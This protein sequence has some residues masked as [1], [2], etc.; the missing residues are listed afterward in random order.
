MSWIPC[1]GSERVDGM[2][3][4]KRM[5]QKAR[6]AQQSRESGN[7]LMNGYL[8]G[9]NDFM[10]GSV[11]RFLGMSDA[12]FSADICSEA[13]DEAGIRR[14]LANTSRSAAERLEFSTKMERQL[15]SFPIIDADEG[16]LP[17]GFRTSALKFFYNSLMMPIVYPV[18]RRAERKRRA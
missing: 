14:A 18:F 12:E 3:C 15:K 4:V 5:A 7:D 16:R 9:D 8:Y 17:P 10:D 6:R 1:S 11:L 2:V 13:D